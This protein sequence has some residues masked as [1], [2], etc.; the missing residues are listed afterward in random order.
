MITEA[1]I[2]HT[3]KW[4]GHFRKTYEEAVPER[5]HSRDLDHDGKPDWSSEMYS[6]MTSTDRRET[7]AEPGKIRLR[8]AM[9]R[10]RNRSLREYE[11]VY[12]VMVMGESVAQVTTWLN[13]RAERG[14][15]PERYTPAKTTV[16]VFAAVD[17]LCAWY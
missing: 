2:A 8:R 17:K 16:I 15:H 9:K 5:I 12:R 7:T 4:L 11:V 3:A 10:L 1:N 6:F 14:G 13:D